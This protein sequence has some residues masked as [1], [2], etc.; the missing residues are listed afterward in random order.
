[1]NSYADTENGH[2]HEEKEMKA[3]IL[4]LNHVRFRA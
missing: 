2:G 3:I 4:A 1:M